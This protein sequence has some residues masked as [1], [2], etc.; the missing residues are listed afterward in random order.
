MEGSLVPGEIG[1]SLHGVRTGERTVALTFD[2]GPR[3]GDTDPV[4]AQLAHAGAYATF[5]TLLVRVRR[6]RLLLA[7]IVAAGHEVALHGFDHRRLTRTDPAVVP[8][9]LRDARAELEDLTGLPV[10]FFRPP[11]GAQNAL[12]WQATVDAGLVPVVWQ[13]ECRDWDTVA[14]DLAFAEL[15]HLEPGMVVLAHDTVAL[16]DDGAEPFDP[17]AVDRGAVTAAILSRIGAQDLVP[18]SLGRA[19]STGT[20]DWR[21]WLDTSAAAAL[22]LAPVGEAE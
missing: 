4:L 14:P 7:E 2:D 3:S 12:V 21:V 1:S 5:F 6:E 19:L 10:R 13:R 11:Y 16:P 8:A 22:P 20:P 17:P 9:L 18:T 15:D